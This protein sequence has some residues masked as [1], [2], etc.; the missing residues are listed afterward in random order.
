MN[1]RDFL[2]TSLIPPAL[3]ASSASA[4]G[5][6]PSYDMVIKGGHVVD[7]ANDIYQR[8]DVAVLDGKVARVEREIPDPA[9]K[10]DHRCGDGYYVTPWPGRHAHLAATTP[11]SMSPHR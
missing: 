9:G 8:M 3:A 2:S 5:R 11:I 6:P 4:T 1:R 10:E 7:P